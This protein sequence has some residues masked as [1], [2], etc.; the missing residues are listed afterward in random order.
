MEIK[1]KMKVA[2][3][4]EK[5]P[6]INLLTSNPL[7]ILHNGQI[8]RGHYHCNGCF[9][10]DDNKLLSKHIDWGHKEVTYW[11]SVKDFEILAV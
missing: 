11:C 7:I 10:S 9:Y 8:N 3:W 5:Y 4:G 1:L 2:K 6:D